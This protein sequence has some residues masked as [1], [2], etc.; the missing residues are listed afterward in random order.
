VVATKLVDMATNALS[1]FASGGQAP[2]WGN[3]T[4]MGDMY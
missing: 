2:N 3:T 1:S 4:P